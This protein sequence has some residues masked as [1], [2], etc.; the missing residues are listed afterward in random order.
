MK[1]DVSF[2]DGENESELDR[3]IQNAFRD[4]DFENNLGQISFS[5]FDLVSGNFQNYFRLV[6]S[7]Y[8]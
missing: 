1:P 2:R 8:V 6:F 4:Y 5:M 7:L 3:I